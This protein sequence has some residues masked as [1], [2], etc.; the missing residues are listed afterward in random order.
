M[1]KMTSLIA[2]LATSYFARELVHA[3]PEKAMGL[4]SFDC[5]VFSVPGEEVTP[6]FV[7]R[8][9]DAVRNSVQA[10]AQAYFSHS[11]LHGKNV[12]DMLKLLADKGKPWE[13]HPW[14]FRRGAYVSRRQTTVTFSAEEIENLPEMHD[15][16]TGR[17]N[18][19][20]RWVVDVELNG[21]AIHN[22]ESIGLRSIAHKI[23]EEN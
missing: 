14:F 20:E 4:P 10:A 22:P 12:D 5:R 21:S 3:V 6:Y 7:W 11:A 18:V 15:A 1:H 2:S 13:D 19:Y 8:E 23:K 9:L 17:S 16:R